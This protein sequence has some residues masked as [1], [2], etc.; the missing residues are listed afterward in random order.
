[1]VILFFMRKNQRE[2]TF[3]L[4]KSLNFF[5]VRKESIILKIIDRSSSSSSFGRPFSAPRLVRFFL[6]SID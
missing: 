4:K 1:M 2:A 3:L 6:N 5:L